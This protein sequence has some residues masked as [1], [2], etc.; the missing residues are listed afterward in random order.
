MAAQISTVNFHGQ[1]LSVISQNNQLYVAMRPVCENIGLQWQSQFNRIKRDEVLNSTVFMMNTVAEDGKNRK[2]LCLPLEYLN[3]WLFGVDEKRV[4]PEI[5][6]RL[7]QYKRECYQVLADYWQGSLPQSS[8][9]LIGKK[10][11]KCLSDLIE[12]KTSHLM[13]KAKTSAKSRLWA[14]VRK[15]YGVDVAADIPADQLDSARQFVGSYV[16]EGDYLPAEP[17]QVAMPLEVTAFSPKRMP[18]EFD[19][20]HGR[21]AAEQLHDCGWNLDLLWAVKWLKEHEGQTV[22]LEPGIADQLSLELNSVLYWYES[23]RN[24]LSSIYQEAKIA[25]PRS[26]LIR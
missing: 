20:R 15:A 10:G 9:R 5:K 6:G 17:Q 8:Q 1:S 16:L 14:Q 12:G 13:G 11:H 7:I 22:R 2:L 19:R 25:A 21:L 3:G 23:Y 4:K 26:A 18:S 24:R